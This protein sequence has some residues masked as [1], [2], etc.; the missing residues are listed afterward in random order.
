MLDSSTAS[1]ANRVRSSANSSTNEST[2]Q[3][4]RSVNRAPTI[5]SANGRHPHSVANRGA[6]D[7]VHLV[8]DAA[9]NDWVGAL[10]ARAAASDVSAYSGVSV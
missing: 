8:I 5:R 4:G 6:A 2:V 1:A 7:R 3:S 9:V 10:F